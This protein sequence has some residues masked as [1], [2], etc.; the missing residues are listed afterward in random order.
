MPY[1][2]KKKRLGTDVYKYKTWI[3]TQLHTTVTMAVR[4]E[5]TYKVT[6]DLE[7]LWWTGDEEDQEAN[8]GKE[9]ITGKIYMWRVIK[10]WQRA[11]GWRRA[12][13][14]TKVTNGVVRDS[15]KLRE[16]GGWRRD[17]S[18]REMSM[19]CEKEMTASYWVDEVDQWR[20]KS[21]QRQRTRERDYR[22]RNANVGF[23]F[24][25]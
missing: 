13:G 21:E 25:D 4:E 15:E 10:R 2:L 22:F 7:L 23:E 20:G 16:T 11:N 14:W 19:A 17:D 5:K 18:N 9:W 3:F 24:G 8:A 12:T 6:Q 1:L